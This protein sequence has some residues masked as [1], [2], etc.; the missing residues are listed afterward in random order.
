MLELT[1]VEAANMASPGDTG[2]SESGPHGALVPGWRR[3]QR[4]HAWAT[5]PYLTGA[6]DAIRV[7]GKHD[8]PR[9]W[10]GS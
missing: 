8:K 1:R 2:W 4:P 5:R 6:L 10:E 9:Q 7:L 3:G